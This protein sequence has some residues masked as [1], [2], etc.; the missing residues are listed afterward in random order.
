LT[1]E[2]EDFLK[3]VRSLA[4]SIAALKTIHH[5]TSSL[6]VKLNQ[7]SRLFNIQEVLTRVNTTQDLIDQIEIQIDNLEMRISAIEHMDF[8]LK[9]SGQ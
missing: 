6:E 1:D 5:R 8:R 7:A 9:T 2:H 4:S 3:I